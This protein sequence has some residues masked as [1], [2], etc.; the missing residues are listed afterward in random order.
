MHTHSGCALSPIRRGGGMRRMCMSINKMPI[1]GHPQPRA[2]VRGRGRAGRAG[3]HLAAKPREPSPRA[4]I[5]K[6]TPHTACFVNGVEDYSIAASRRLQTKSGLG[7]CQ[8]SLSLP[9]GC[10]QLPTPT[11]S[12]LDLSEL[13]GL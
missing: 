2:V 6:V 1:T 11:T 10:E 3:P 8:K 7:S 9:L 12:L 5:G 4:F 13:K